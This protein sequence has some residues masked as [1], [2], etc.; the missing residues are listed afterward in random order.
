MKR[1]AFVGMVLVLAVAA[2][3]LAQADVR[4]DEGGV[5][6]DPVHANPVGHGLALTV[7]VDYVD[8]AHA[9]RPSGGAPCTDTDQ[10][11]YADPFA[12]ARNAGLT[13]RVNTATFPS[14][15]AAGALAAI[16]NAAGAWNGVS[17][18]YFSV[19]G[20]STKTTPAQDGENSIGWVKIVPRKVLAAT[21]T[22]TDANNRIVEADVFYNNAH[23]WATLSSCGGSSFDV[24]DIGTH[25]LGHTVGLSH[26]TDSESQATMY[27]S[28]PAGEIRKNTLTSGDEAAFGISLG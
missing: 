25:E 5:P 17:G 16:Q 10:A 3:L 13:M 19:S 4:A 23:P 8:E 26:Y 1:L 14:S 24:Q 20:G 6:A 11:G 21:W 28:A 27:P 12:Q 2:A 18:G 9:G 7:T 22:W 15:V